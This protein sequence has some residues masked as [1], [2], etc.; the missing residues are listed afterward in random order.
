MSEIILTIEEIS[1]Y[2]Q[3]ILDE[4][5]LF[6][7]SIVP[8]MIVNKDRVIVRVNKRFREL[9]DYS[10]EEILGRQTSMLTPSKEKFE[11][12]RKYFIQTQEGIVQ[13]E[14]LLYKKKDGTLFW[15]K[16]EGIRIYGDDNDI[17]ILWSFG[18]I[19]KEVKYREKLKELA[20]VDPMTGLYNRRYFM[21]VSSNI[22]SLAKRDGSEL[23]IIMLDIDKFKNI[24]DTYG[25]HIGDLV[26]I[27]L[28]DILKQNIRT[29]DIICRFGGEEFIIL[30]PE[31]GIDDAYNIAE[32]IRKLI[33]TYELKIQDNT[34]LKFTASF[35]IGSI[36][37]IYDTNIENSIKK[38]DKALYRAKHSGR[39]TVVKR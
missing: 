34:I 6:E 11:E 38:A 30:V 31:T 24:N 5:T 35:G 37:T 36:D 18:D 16:L 2:N 15:T 9:F 12:Y 39:N 3:I 1:K 10:T 7:L 21:D 27:A 4:N 28:S 14:E 29:S 32:K 23:S 19:D 17:L 25:H 8:Q 20:T 22:L 33:Q 26:I 13:S